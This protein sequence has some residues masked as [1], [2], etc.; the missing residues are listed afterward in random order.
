MEAEMKA[1][2]GC[3]PH[4]PSTFACCDQLHDPILV[5][6]QYNFQLA[7]FPFASLAVTLGGPGPGLVRSIF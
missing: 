2:N 5:S 7:D 6:T 4:D 1:E 3:L